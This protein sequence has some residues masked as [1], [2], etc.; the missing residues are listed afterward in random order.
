[1]DLKSYGR[2]YDYARARDDMFEATDTEWAPWYVV[3]PT[4]S[5]AD[6]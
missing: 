2:W 4:T 5:A 1:M 6:G 3:T